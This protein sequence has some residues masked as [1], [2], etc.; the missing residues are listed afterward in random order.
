MIRSTCSKA[1]LGVVLALLA[2]SA[3][4]AELKGV[5]PSNPQAEPELIHP[6][7]NSRVEHLD[8]GLTIVLHQ[9]RRAPVIEL[10]LWY[11]VGAIDEPAG[12]TG[13]SHALEHMMFQGTSTTPPGEYNRRIAKLGGRK[14]AYTTRD[15]TYYY[16]V[17]P[18]SDLGV[19]LKLEAD[20]MLH[21]SLAD[22]QFGNE[23]KVV[24]EERRLNT[25]N[26]AF[27]AFNERLER[28][29]YPES[30][31]SN[32][33][34]GH[35]DDLKKLKAADLRRWYQQWYTPSNAILVLAGDFESDVAL[36]QIRRE[37]GALPGKS[38]PERIK[39]T[40]PIQQVGKRLKSKQPA[41]NSMVTFRW[42]L[43]TQL[44][45]KDRAALAM[46]AE[47]LDNDYQDRR[48]ALASD[49]LGAYFDYPTR[50][51]PSFV[52]TATPTDD[53]SLSSLESA[54]DKQVSLLR[55]AGLYGEMLERG[56]A[57]MLAQ[58]YFSFDSL[59]NR[60][61]ELGRSV[62]Y[63]E[64]PQQYVAGLA[65]MQQV[66]LD[67]LERVAETY[68]NETN[69]SVGV[70]DALPVSDMQSVSQEVTHGR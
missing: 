68:L 31:M 69:R 41:A 8:N 62:L 34:I 70:L 2:L 1:A 27:R 7:T 6:L 3:L 42:R 17:L 21:L 61:T 26:N 23:I 52:L 38:L 28:V 53:T 25:E 44:P 51:E 54:M 14:N 64:T 36:A 66:T 15:Y 65:R 22:D 40:E 57:R 11:R 9:D 59:S 47:M 67:D 24:M 33:V 45:E 12:L 29:V 30:V 5:L 48:L 58:N 46:L 49:S 56:K 13:I 10:Q 60:A 63:G 55:G 18:A 43:P 4:A 20:R 35:M 37:F 39:V 16:S 32:P 19:A 50:G